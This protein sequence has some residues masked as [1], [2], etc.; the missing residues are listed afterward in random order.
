M[1]DDISE[2]TNEHEEP[3][4]PVVTAD[5]SEPDAPVSGPD[6]G[7]GA[8]AP[9]TASVRARVDR[10]RRATTGVRLRPSI[11]TTRMSAKGTSREGRG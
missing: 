7:E 8:P 1:A 9:R 6:H 4:A 2:P 5:P 11:R 3:D 10:H